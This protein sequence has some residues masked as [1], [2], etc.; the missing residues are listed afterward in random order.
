MRAIIIDDKDARVL[1]E[2]LELGAMKAKATGYRGNGPNGEHTFDDIHRTFHYI[3]TSWLT[4]Q[5]CNVIR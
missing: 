4:E 2:R 1:L 5:G 3:V